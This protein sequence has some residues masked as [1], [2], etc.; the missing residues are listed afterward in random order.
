MSVKVSL[1]ENAVTVK[2]YPKLMITNYGLIVLFT[3][4]ETGT[5]INKI[6]DYK[7]GYYSDDWNDSNFKDY[8][9]EVTLKN[10]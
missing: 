1:K 2:G 5:V 6:N 10:E 9:G 4:E 3:S 8:N 7:L